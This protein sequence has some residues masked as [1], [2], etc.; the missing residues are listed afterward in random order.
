MKKIG[1]ALIGA[2]HNTELKARAGTLGRGLLICVCGFGD[3]AKQSLKDY[4]NSLQTN[5]L[6]DVDMIVHSCFPGKLSGKTAEKATAELIKDL[7]SHCEGR[8]YEE[9]VFLAH[10]FSAAIVRKVLIVANFKVKS[11]TSILE[12]SLQD[13]AKIKRHWHRNVSEIVFAAGNTR[14]WLRSPR[15]KLPDSILYFYFGFVASIFGAISRQSY[16]PAIYRLR[17]GSPFIFNTRIQWLDLTSNSGGKRLSLDITHMIPTND[18]MISSIEVIDLELLKAKK[19]LL[20]VEVPETDQNTILHLLPLVNRTWSKFLPYVQRNLKAQTA[21]RNAL[22]LACVTNRKPGS[23]FYMKSSFATI[24]QHVVQAKYLDDKVITTPNN[25]IQRYVFIVHGIRDTG[26]WAKKVGGRIR[27]FHKDHVQK[28]DRL[29]TDT[30]SY[31]YFTALPFLLP[32]VR[33]TKVEWLMDRYATAKALYPRAEI[34]FVGHSNGTYLAA[35]GLK[36]YLNCSFDRVV[37]AGSVVSKNFDWDEIRSNKKIRKILN[38]VAT[39]DYVVAFLPRAF[40][41]LTFGKIDLG[42]AGHNGFKKG[43]QAVENIKYAIGKH[44]AALHENNREEFAEFICKGTV[45][46]LNRNNANFA[47]KRNLL[48]QLLSNLS[49][50]LPIFG[51]ALVFTIEAMIFQSLFGAQIFVVTPLQSAYDYYTS[52]EPWSK[53]V[54][55]FAINWLIWYPLLFL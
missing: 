20:F 8:E 46:Q 45:P 34:S 21:N 2:G 13:L 25:L 42:S 37:F 10:G 29:I 17:R 3:D 7:D 36:D 31:G 35:S 47:S 11:A 54:A 14:G 22:V 33:K 15:W 16:V 51:V 5:Y 40:E 52:F 41:Q 28:D 12:D 6:T 30:Q 1:W 26:A 24:A 48:F 44:D 19:Q 38:Y 49:F 55:A 18:R 50:L 4:C 32:W 9:I 23:P 43:G 27:Q 39:R 53:V